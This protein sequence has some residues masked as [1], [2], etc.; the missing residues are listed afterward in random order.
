MIYKAKREKNLKIIVNKHKFE[1]SP[2]FSMGQLRNFDELIKDS[3][4]DSIQ[5]LRELIQGIII[6]G[7]YDEITEHELVEITKHF[8]KNRDYKY[9]EFSNAQSAL[10]QIENYFIQFN[11]ELINAV[12]AAADVAKSFVDYAY[13]IVDDAIKAITESFNFDEILEQN[14]ELYVAINTIAKY[15]WTACDYMELS[16]II[17]IGRT[18]KRST[19]NHNEIQSIIDET[20]ARMLSSKVI[21]QIFD[22]IKSNDLVI[23]RE[24]IIDEIQFAYKHKKY[25][26]GV[27]SLISLIE[28]IFIDNKFYKEKFSHKK[29]RDKISS[30]SVDSKING[31]SV[32]NVFKYKF[33]IIFY[34]GID[35]IPNEMSRHAIIHGVDTNCGN[36]VTFL[37]VLLILNGIVE[38]LTEISK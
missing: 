25:Y 13:E 21:N 20:L 6:D 7:Y 24:H 8:L 16:K 11:N 30:M 38:L 35:N 4:I 3:E 22:E 28:G 17:K 2:F 12:I 1:M 31:M 33:H 29:M 26:L 9:D 23:S 19:E 36:E 34:P 5:Q 10:I 18:V 15:G 37:K 32:L 14:E 27:V